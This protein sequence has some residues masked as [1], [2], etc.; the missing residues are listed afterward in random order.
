MSA[1]RTGLRIEGATENNLRDVDVTLSEGISA[2]VGASGSGK[3][4]LVFDTLYRE[5]RHRFLATLQGAQGTV[6]AARVR[7]VHGLRPAVAVGQNVLN[8]NPRS[9]VATAV[10]VHPFLRVI[11]ARFAVLRCPRCAATFERVPFHYECPKCGT[12]GEPTDI[13]KEMDIEGFTFA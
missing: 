11:Y 7:G 13:G 6:R 10:G 5:A 1:H 4:S 8:R 3:S 2:V 12:P 9:T